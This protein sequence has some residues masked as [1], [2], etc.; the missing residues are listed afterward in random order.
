MT[1]TSPPLWALL[2]LSLSIATMSSGG[3]WF[4][5]LDPTPPLMQA[6][7]RLSL[8]AAMQSA[9]VAYELHTDK[10]LDAAFWRRFRRALPLTLTIGLALAAYFGSWG[11]SVAH[12]SLLDSL[13]LVCTTPLV[14]V[15]IMTLR[16]LYRRHDSSTQ[17]TMMTQTPSLESSPLVRKPET[18]DDDD[19]VSCATSWFETI[20][21]PRHA[22]PPTWM[23]VLGATVGFAGVATLLATT[24]S[25]S[26]IDARHH[27][28]L[29][30]NASA[31]VGAVVLIVYLE[32]CASSRKWMPLFLYSFSVTSIGAVAL[33][34]ASLVLESHTTLTGFGPAALLGCFGD[35][36]RLALA[37]GAAFFA[38]FF[39]HATMNVAIVYVSPLL[40]SVAAL[41]EPLIG[42]ILGYLVGVQGAPDK[43]ALVAAPL[44]LGGALLVT[45]G[46]RDVKTK[47]KLQ[48]TSDAA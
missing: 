43:V 30:G 6:C 12:T 15:V 41:S 35:G 33:G 37:L 28:S 24:P 4:A 36:R 14:L 44:L 29:L 8:T 32:G 2:L 48:A 9:G 5:L 13:L 19:G 18:V 3:I 25:S 42:S 21:C 47:S 20:V 46:G 16:W 17:D 7:W 22:L 23:E 27:A 26:S 39:G 40:I 31:L 45:L 34:L 11:F 38:G 1:R 10:A